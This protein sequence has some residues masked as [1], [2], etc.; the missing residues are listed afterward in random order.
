MG[1]ALGPILAHFILDTYG[2]PH[3]FLPM[4]AYC[5]LM[6][7]GAVVLRPVDSWTTQPKRKTN[8]DAEPLIKVGECSTSN[9]LALPTP[10]V[11]GTAMSDTTI[12]VPPRPWRRVRCEH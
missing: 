10:L 3:V 5:L 1:G 12:V 11:S 4:A 2:M 8:D 7:L 6:A 9:T